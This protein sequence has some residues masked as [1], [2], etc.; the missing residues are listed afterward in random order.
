MNHAESTHRTQTNRERRPLPILTSTGMDKNKDL[1][2]KYKTIPPNRENNSSPH[3]QRLRH[4]NVSFHHRTRMSSRLEFGSPPRLLMRLLKRII[5]IQL[6]TLSHDQGYVSIPEAGSWSWLD[7]VVLEAPDAKEP[8]LSNT[9]NL[10][11]GHDT[12]QIGDQFDRS[13]DI[14]KALEP[15]N[16]IGVRVCARFPGSWEHYVTSGSLDI[17]TADDEFQLPELDDERLK[18]INF[19]KDAQKT[20]LRSSW[21]ITSIAR[22]LNPASV[23]PCTRDAFDRPGFVPIWQY[24]PTSLPSKLYPSMAE[25]FAAS[26]PWQFC[27]KSSEHRAL[28]VLPHDCWHE[29]RRPDCYH[30]GSSSAHRTTVH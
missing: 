25:A 8:K 20:S 15:G 9:N 19:T 5:K 28:R 4:G 13:H 16:A 29:H 24:H 14:F 23:L 21:T 7:I 12:H 1:S 18:A 26:H 17:R 22:R 3:W 11:V 10:G 30:A 6:Q 27:N 2:K